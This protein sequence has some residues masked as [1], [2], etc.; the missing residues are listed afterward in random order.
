MLRLKFKKRWKGG[1]I[2]W[3]LINAQARSTLNRY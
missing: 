1:K 3:L 2:Y